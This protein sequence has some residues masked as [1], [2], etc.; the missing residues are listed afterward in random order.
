MPFKYLLSGNT[1]SGRT[2]RRIRNQDFSKEGTKVIHDEKL[3][4]GMD[5][6]VYLKL[7]L[8]EN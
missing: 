7:F 3:L 5:L 6:L 2:E 4:L 8:W 1:S